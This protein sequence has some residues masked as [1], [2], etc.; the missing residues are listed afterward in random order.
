MSA[1]KGERSYLFKKA[2]YYTGKAATRPFVAM[3]GSNVEDRGCRVVERE[4]LLVSPPI[5]ITE[6][7][8]KRLT[9]GRQMLWL[10]YNL[11]VWWLD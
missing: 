7:E 1:A 8:A 5:Q 4:L 3:V 9:E 11:F 2:A 10:A 6:K